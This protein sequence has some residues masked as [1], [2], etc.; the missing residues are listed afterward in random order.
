T[1][2]AG[3]V[4]AADATAQGGDL[5]LSGQINLVE[6]ARQLPATIHLRPDAQVAS[7]A[8]E[9]SLASQAAANGRRWAG[10]LK[11]RDIR[12]VA[13]G[14]QI[15]FDQPLEVDFDLQQTPAG[16][17]LEQLVGQASFLRLEGRGA[18]ADGSIKADADLDRLV[19]ELDRLI[20]WGDTRMEGK[21]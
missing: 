12:G 10:Q 21:L 20:N 14:R 2:P 11:T 19:S 5:E 1:V 9:F 15:Q 8:V 6:L 13:A 16:P 4:G 3:K 18:L 17:V 7:G